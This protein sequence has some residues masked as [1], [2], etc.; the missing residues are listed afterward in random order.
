MKNSLILFLTLSLLILTTTYAQAA[1]KRAE[2]ATPTREKS[3]VVRAQTDAHYLMGAI[4]DRRGDLEKAVKEYRE[5]A[6]W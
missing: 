1:V 4:Y 6:L 3:E 2:K 5:T